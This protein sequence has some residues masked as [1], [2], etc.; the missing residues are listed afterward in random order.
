MGL[1]RYQRH[2]IQDRTV[3]MDSEMADRLVSSSASSSLRCWV[4]AE[5]FS[6]RSRNDDEGLVAANSRRS[7]AEI[8]EKGQPDP[9]L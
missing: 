8:V 7:D 4:A 1:M 6:A 5:T 9:S 2:Q 3:L